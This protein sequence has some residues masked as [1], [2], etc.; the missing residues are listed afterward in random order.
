MPLPHHHLQLLAATEQKFAAAASL[1]DQLE[2]IAALY[3][4]SF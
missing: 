3:L 2:Q 4:C 1:G